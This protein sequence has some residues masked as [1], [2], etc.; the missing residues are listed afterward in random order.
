MFSLEQCATQLGHAPNCASLL[1]AWQKW[2]RGNPLPLVSEVR[3]EDLGPALASTSILEIH[4]PGKIVYR[5]FA[6]LHADVIGRDLTGENLI[7]MTPPADR[8]VRKQRMLAMVKQPCG[9]MPA[10]DLTRPSGTKVHI[11][12]LILPVRPNDEAQP[13]RLYLALDLLG[14]TIPGDD[15]EIETI[16]ITGQVGPIDLGFGLPGL[17]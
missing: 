10:M 5:L 11:Q 7:E 15:G 4:D 17:A 1:T 8:E 16:P 2:R 9:G 12:V 3:A 6:S 14:E 13:M